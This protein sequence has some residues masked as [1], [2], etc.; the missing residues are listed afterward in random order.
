[1]VKLSSH[2][3]KKEKVAFWHFSKGSH[4][5]IDEFSL[6]ENSNNI[7]TVAFIFIFVGGIAV[8]QNLY[9]TECRHGIR[10]ICM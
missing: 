4:V 5:F 3:M 2:R 6:V 10:K 9:R 7:T 1:M 8:C